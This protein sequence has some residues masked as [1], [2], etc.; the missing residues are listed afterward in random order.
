MVKIPKGLGGA[1]KRLGSNLLEITYACYLYG[2]E[3]KEEKPMNF[4]EFSKHIRQVHVQGQQ[5]RNKLRGAK[6]GGGNV[7]GTDAETRA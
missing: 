7:Q 3:R 1:A 2:Y 6:N 4:L 5:I